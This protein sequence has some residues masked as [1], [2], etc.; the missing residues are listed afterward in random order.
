MKINIDGRNYSFKFYHK[1]DGD[2]QGKQPTQPVTKLSR[3]ALS[4][5][6]ERAT[7][8]IVFNEAGEEVTSGTANVHPK[9]NFCKEKGRQIALARAIS[10]WDKAY[11][12]KV[13]EEYR[14]W[15]ATNRW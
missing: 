13:W 3:K 14:T 1:N 2:T 4:A 11:R 6:V 7:T 8:C 10:S 12:T 5:P 15:G 9:D